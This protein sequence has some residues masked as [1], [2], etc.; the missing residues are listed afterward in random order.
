MLASLVR[1]VVAAA[2]SIFYRLER[3]GPIVPSGPVLL[4][5]NHP[6]SLLDPVVIFATAGR[7]PRPLAKAPLFER[8]VVGRLIRWVG[9]IPVYRREDGPV[10]IGGN[11]DSF[12]AATA[13]LRDGDAVQ[14]FPE[15]RSHSDPQLSQ[16]RTGAARISLAA[17]SEADWALGLAVVP[18]GLT[19][20]R[21]PF[22]RGRAVALY[23]GPIA[24]AGYRRA[25]EEDAF[26]AARELT[27]ELDRRLRSLT[28][29]LTEAEDGRLVD[30]A[31]KVWVR[32]K[33]VHSPRER[34]ALADRLPRLQEFARGLAWLRLHD[35]ARYQR[36]R[37]DVS[38]Y[39][40]MTDLLA[41]GEGDVP[42]RYALVPT[43][44][45]ILTSLLPVLVLSP[46]AALAGVVWGIPYRTVGWAVE[47]MRLPTDVVA[48][49]RWRAPWSH[50]R[51]GSACGLRWPPGSGAGPEPW[52]RWC[53][54]RCSGCSPCAG[55]MAP[56]MRWRT[57]GSS[58]ASLPAGIAWSGSAGCDGR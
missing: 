21:K 43:L 34:P 31:E 27:A 17:E 10:K 56:G 47:R 29:N 22:F 30:A 45:W 24:V 54:S 41:V 20:V 39:V 23:G 15:G 4:A 8:A 58:V 19:Y 9:G 38:S 12:R 33:G 7:T 25:F 14:I 3:R 57:C 44:R 52:R 28:L 36:L 18:V 13:A 53:C 5:A 55:S 6:N 49:Y 16:L 26:Q 42:D 50:T 11:Q 1:T 35:P 37:H 32:E 51:S 46:L 2:V 48:T 40:R